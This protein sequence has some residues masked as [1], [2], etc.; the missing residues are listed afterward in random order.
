MTAASARQRQR[1]PAVRRDLEVQA[2]LRNA[3]GQ[4]AGVTRMYGD[5]RY[6]LDVLDQLAAVT[7]AL[8]AVAL[9]ILEDHTH[10]C[11]R[12]A[13][14]DGDPDDAV[15]ELAAAVRRYVRSR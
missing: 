9:L 6:C 14:T 13:V 11:V 10:T 7:A 3:S 12:A 2:R 1:M 8:D 5:G 4:L 15:T